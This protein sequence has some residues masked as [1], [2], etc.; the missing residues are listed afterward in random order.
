MTFLISFI[1]ADQCCHSK[2]IASFLEV[3][4]FPFG[5]FYSYFVLAKREVKYMT[6]KQ[7]PT[8]LTPEILVTKNRGTEKRYLYVY[9]Q[10]FPSSKKKK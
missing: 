10:K 3:Y 2:N 5:A 9:D 7:L 4:P 1:T 8:N 6:R